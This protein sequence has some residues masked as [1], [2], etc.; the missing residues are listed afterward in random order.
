[1]QGKNR[2]IFEKTF[3]RIFLRLAVAGKLP[4]LHL[5]K[6]RRNRVNWGERFVSDWSLITDD[7]LLVT[8]RS[9]S[10]AERLVVVFVNR[11]EGGVRVYGGAGADHGFD[12]GGEVGEEGH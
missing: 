11:D 12:G 9:T 6:N 5:V 2:E 4:A 8:T 3:V 10:F 1:M 7:W